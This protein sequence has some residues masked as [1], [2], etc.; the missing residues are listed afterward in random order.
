MF[1]TGVTGVGSESFSYQWYHNWSI[2]NGENRKGLSITNVTDYNSGYY[3]C[4]V[5]N[6]YGDA[7]T[8]N[9]AM[10]KVTSELEQSCIYI[11][12]CVCGI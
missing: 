9:A 7:D 4:I 11:A 1:N 10:L 12:T 8:S 5:T 2:I 6:Y 3:D